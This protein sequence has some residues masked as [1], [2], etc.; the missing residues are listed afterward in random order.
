MLDAVYGQAQILWEKPTPITVSGA[1]DVLMNGTLVG[2]WNFTSTSIGTMTVNGVAFAAVPYNVIPSA[3]TIVCSNLRGTDNAFGNSSV[4]PGDYR[5]I[6]SSG[7]YANE[8]TNTTPIVLT[9]NNL[10]IGATYQVKFWVHDERVNHNGHSVIFYTG[11]TNSGNVFVNQGLTPSNANP[12]N[13]VVCEFLATA[14]TQ[15]F[16]VTGG[17]TANSAFLN[18]LALS[19][20]PEPSTWLLTVSGL[21]VLLVPFLKKRGITHA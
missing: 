2:A 12:G 11:T 17:D 6:V 4:L 21:G 18:A 9:L 15:Q 13:L 5:G 3:L 7:I 16:T 19:V 8:S 10:T 20:I 1:N 14:D